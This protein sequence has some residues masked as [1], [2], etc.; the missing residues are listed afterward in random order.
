MHSS[1]IYYFTYIKKALDRFYKHS[2]LTKISAQLT[3]KLCI[4]IYTPITL[5]R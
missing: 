3:H 4:N 2:K 5:K 1:N